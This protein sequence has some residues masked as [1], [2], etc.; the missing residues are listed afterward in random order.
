MT[1]CNEVEEN[2]CEGLKGKQLKTCKDQQQGEGTEDSQP[3]E[4]EVV[5]NDIADKTQRKAC[6]KN[7]RKNTD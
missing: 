5:C 2:P 3:E 7:K 1:P 6:K 4:E